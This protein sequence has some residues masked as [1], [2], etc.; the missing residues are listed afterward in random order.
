MV[1]AHQAEWMRTVAVTAGRNKGFSMCNKTGR[2]TDYKAK[3]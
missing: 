2:D 3:V 1:H